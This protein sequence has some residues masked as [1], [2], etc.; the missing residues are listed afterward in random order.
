MRLI[1]ADELKQNLS[2][3]VVGGEKAIEKTTYENSWIY[4]IHTA[5]REINE[6]PTIEIPQWIPCTDR[7]PEKTGYYLVSDRRGDVY[8]TNFDYLR[9][10]MCFGYDDLDGCFVKDD[11]VIAWMPL[12]EPYKREGEKE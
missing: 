4:G 6:A 9:G 7:L 5:Y 1:D 10:E 12:P 3:L 2:S 11:T 8:S